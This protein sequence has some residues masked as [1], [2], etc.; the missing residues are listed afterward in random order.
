MLLWFMKFLQQ[1][2]LVNYWVLLHKGKKDK[3]VY[4][5]ERKNGAM[6][7]LDEKKRKKIC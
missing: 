1:V 3:K 4:F 2:E 5:C 7:K 6:E